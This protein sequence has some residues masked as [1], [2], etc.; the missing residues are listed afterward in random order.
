MKA[1]IFT[2]STAC[3]ALATARGAAEAYT[4][5]AETT[6]VVAGDIAEFFII[7]D[8]SGHDYEALFIAREPAD[9]I[10]AAV[11]KMGVPAGEGVDYDKFKFWAKGERVNMSVKFPGKDGEVALDSLVMDARTGKP[12][13]EAGFVF[14]GAEIRENAGPGSIVS[15]YNEAETLFDVPRYCIQGDVY[16][17]FRVVEGFPT[18]KGVVVEITIRPEE[19]HRRVMD[20]DVEFSKKGMRVGADAEAEAA[21]DAVV[22]L[23]ALVKSGRDV[24][25]TPIWDE[26][27]TV[28]QVRDYARLL[29][30]LDVDDGVRVGPPAKDDPYYK[31]FDP[32]EDWRDRKKRF[33]QPCELR[34]GEDGA[35]TLVAI[36]EIWKDDE[37]MPELKVREFPGVA[38]EKLPEM[39]RGKDNELKVLLVFAPGGVRYGVV[40]PFLEKIKNTHPNLHVFV[41]KN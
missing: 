18:N 38:A 24:F 34:F 37:I 22:K 25:V 23:R 21:K 10:R 35:A 7:D 13:R 31:A 3:L 12:L 5:K 19:A 11:L 4:F 26:A 14:V 27:L 41:E 29:K 6:G 28:A 40:K 30:L 15:S 1:I 2:V 33:A 9:E 39:M 17:K 16:E 36:E 20:L 8:K 32:P